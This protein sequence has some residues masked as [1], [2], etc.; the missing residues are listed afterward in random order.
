MRRSR[1][2]GRV[3]VV[4]HV[5]YQI[6]LGRAVVAV[7]A[8][9]GASLASNIVNA[10]SAPQP[11]L[12]ERQTIQQTFSDFT[13][14]VRLKRDGCIAS[15]ASDR[16]VCVGVDGPL[17]SKK[18]FKSALNSDTVLQCIFWG[19]GCGNRNTEACAFST[20]LARTTTSVNYATP[21]RY[22]NHWQVEVTLKD[23]EEC[24]Q[25]VRLI[26]TLESGFWRTVAIPYT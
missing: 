26:W 8:F 13:Q 22:Q 24:K 6:W 16:G 21:Y 18:T 4:S 17:F 20:L 19:K 5:R 12:E 11:A 1:E 2:A 3:E 14:C 9:A 10:Q 23:S 25:D 7:V 15:L